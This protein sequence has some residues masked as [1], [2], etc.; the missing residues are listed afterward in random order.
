MTILFHQNFNFIF[1][2][3]TNSNLLDFYNNSDNQYN[4]MLNKKEKEIKR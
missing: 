1:E 4:K 3:N 2:I